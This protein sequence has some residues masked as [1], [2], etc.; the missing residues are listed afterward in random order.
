M[1]PEIESRLVTVLD[2]IGEAVKSNQ[3]QVPEVAQEIVNRALVTSCMMGVIFFVLAFGCGAMS[4]WAWVAGANAENKED[5]GFTALSVIGFIFLVIF[6]G[7]GL[8]N[9]YNFASVYVAPRVYVLEWLA[10]QAK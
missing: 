5:E 8:M 9:A 6:T 7:L 2:Y 1:N 3:H 4:R 10:A